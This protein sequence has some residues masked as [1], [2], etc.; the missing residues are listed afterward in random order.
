MSTPA[1]ESQHQKSS[2][3]GWDRHAI[4]AAVHRQGFSLVAL[5]VE[6]GLS[7]QACSAALNIPFPAADRAISECIGVPL[8]ERARLAGV[9]VDAVFDSVSVATTFKQRLADAGVIFG[10]GF[11]PYT[12]G[13]LNY[14]ASRY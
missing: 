9:A 4:V 5:A 6:N 11:A 3:S 10:T 7:R 12:G 13:P 14:L 8:H 2:P 1:R